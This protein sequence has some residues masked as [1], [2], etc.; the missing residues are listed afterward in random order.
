MWPFKS[1]P[2]IETKS[3][4]EPDPELLAI[5]GAASG[6]GAVSAAVAMTVPAVACAV[7]VI[8]EAA[9]SL[10]V[11]VKRKDGGAE[12][13]VPDHPAAVLLK[14]A[15]NG[16][17]S[18]YE[19][20][21][22]LVA[23]ALTND[24][25]GL[26]WVNRVGG[27][28]REVIHYS[29][30]KLAVD[31]AADGTGEPT[32]SL[33]ARL[34]PAEDIIH[35]RGPFSRCPLSL[36]ATA[37]GLAH[38]LES[39]GAHLFQNGAKP[40]GLL[41][42]DKP[43][44]HKGS[45][46]AA[47]GWK[48]AYGGAANSGNVAILWD[49]MSFEALSMVSTDAQYLENRQFQILEIARAFRVPPGMLFELTR[50]TWGNSEQQAKE[51]IQYTLVPW[52]RALEAALNRALLTAEERASGFRIAFDIDDTS[53]ADLTARASAIS[54][55]ITAK[56]L[57]PNEARSWLGME[58]RAG[59]ETYENPAITPTPANSNAEKPLEHQIAI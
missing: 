1:R 48:A 36:A 52:V 40:G 13:D 56:V 23:Q 18:G 19:L 4:A 59:G 8:S 15:A 49:G 50:N 5:F 12:V 10:D 21:R 32:Y 25:G 43:L 22:D 34:L 42:T 39:Y 2:P 27:E 29:P 51:F 47:R 20:L 28:I 33:D 53:Q 9:A 44:G 45:Q 37:I 30:G 24:R 17:T 16:W 38:S 57:N 55:L 11:T 6:V 31:Y 41:K 14:G 3:L 7:R 58:P 35:L 54:T 46:E 26:A